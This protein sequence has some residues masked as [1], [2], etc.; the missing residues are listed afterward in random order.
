M[1]RP[2]K[3]RVIEEYLKTLDR[4]QKII[5]LGII[6][7]A[8]IIF[9]SSF[10]LIKSGKYASFSFF[11]GIMLLSCLVESFPPLSSFVRKVESNKVKQLEKAI[12]RLLYYW[13][14]TLVLTMIIITIL[15]GYTGYLIYVISQ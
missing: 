13:I 10:V 9:F 7:T 1:K 5:R 6:F 11:I 2:H 14:K 8:I 15:F 12:R 3:D 4:W